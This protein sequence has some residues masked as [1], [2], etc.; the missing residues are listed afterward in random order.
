MSKKIVCM[1]IPCYNEVDN[2][3]PM[4]EQLMELFERQLPQYRLRIQFI[5]N[6]STD[7]TQKKLRELCEKY[8]QVRVILNAK[9][10]PM[11]SGYHGIMQS[12]GDCTIA[13]PCDFQVPLSVVP[14]LL[15]KWENGAKIVCLVKKSAEE[16]GLMWRVR[17]LFYRITDSLSNGPVIRNYNGSGLYDNAFLSVCRKIDDPAPSFLQHVAILGYDIEKVEYVH[18]RRKSGRSKNNLLML[19]NIAISR[20]VNASSMGPRIATIGGLFCGIVSFIIGCVYLVLKLMFWNLF[21]AGMAPVLIG[22]F[23]MGSLQLFFIGL[24][25]EYLMKVNQR[26]MKRPLVVERERLNFGADEEA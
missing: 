9:N 8:P 4:A 23:F 1:S 21:A 16:S 7:G 22:V 24:L 10:F 6:S 26:L 5:D 2:V 3:V 17:Q 13:M 11:T 12:E 18:A 19:V 25:G 15:E 14:Q 20:F